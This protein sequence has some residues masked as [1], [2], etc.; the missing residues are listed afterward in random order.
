MQQLASPVCHD[1]MEFSPITSSW[2]SQRC[3]PPPVLDSA[4]FGPH[5]HTVQVR[6]WEWVYLLKFKVPQEHWPYC[7]DLQRRTPSDNW[8][9]LQSLDCCLLDK[10]KH[11]SQKFVL[12]SMGLAPWLAKNK[13][14][15]FV[16]LGSYYP[17]GKEGSSKL[18]FGMESVE[19][20]LIWWLFDL[21]CTCKEIRSLL[22]CHKKTRFW[23]KAGSIT[24]AYNLGSSV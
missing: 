22:C 7:L 10:Q 17:W 18:F 19:M 2:K 23:C 16:D 5:Y 21:T 11:N 1:P 20:W 6:L 3:F 12:Q 13:E 24:Y 8:L 4:G 15:K 9:T 14:G